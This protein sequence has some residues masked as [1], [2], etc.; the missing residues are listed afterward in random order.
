MYKVN[1]VNAVKLV[2]ACYDVARVEEGIKNL[3]WC[4]KDRHLFH[5]LEMIAKGRA[6]IKVIQRSDEVKIPLSDQD[7]FIEIIKRL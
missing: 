3:K 5:A 1:Q 6:I 2:S 7:E 4:A